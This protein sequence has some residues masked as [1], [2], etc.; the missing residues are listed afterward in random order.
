MGLFRLLLASTIMLGHFVAFYPNHLPYLMY[1]WASVPA[2]YIVSGFL[3]TLV[4]C[5]RYHD[6]L[7]LFYSNRALRIFPLY[8]AA[9]VLFLAVNWL[10]AADYLPGPHQHT[11]TN[12]I[13][14][15][16]A[17]ANE[18][19][20]L[21]TIMM[22]FS[23]VAI[24]GQDWMLFIGKWPHIFSRDYFY[25]F[26]MYVGP[27]WTIEVEFVFYAIAPF[28]VLRSVKWTIAVLIASLLA[29]LIAVKALGFTAYDNAYDFPPFEMAFFMGGSLAYRVY[30]HLREQ[31]PEWI[32]A[33]SYGATLLIALLSAFYLFIPFARPIY[34]VAACLCL[35]GIVL[36]GRRNPLD[37]FL[38]ELSYPI[39]LLHPIF[40]IF[41]IPGAGLLPEVIAVAGVLALSTFL[42]L[43]VDRPLEAF[44]HR[45][46]KMKAAAASRAME[47][48]AAAPA[49]ST[50]EARGLGSA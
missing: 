23:N 8:W 29:R 35:P 30:A 22:I 36:L 26:F 11:G 50:H 24:V 16:R 14:W 21:A 40:T 28:V 46:A 48:P 5:E 17:H 44:R 33:Y 9:L 15:W 2:F 31:K 49:L 42:I 41:V 32:T 37:N 10:V 19:G 12:A 3:I 25:H 27:A 4:I 18:I 1:G 39:Y 6:R 7:W 13:Y 47:F 38:G 20:P 45:R 34:L 43:A